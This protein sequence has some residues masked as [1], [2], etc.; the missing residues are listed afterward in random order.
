M[1]VGIEV[2]FTD[3]KEGGLHTA[4]KMEFTG[5]I[6]DAKFLNKLEFEAMSLVMRAAGGHHFNFDEDARIAAIDDGTW[7]PEGLGWPRPPR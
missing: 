2:R 3:E 4:E 1:K 7:P 6:S 5:D